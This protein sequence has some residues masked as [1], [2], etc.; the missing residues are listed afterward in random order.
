MKKFISRTIYFV[1]IILSFTLLASCSNKIK[2]TSETSSY[3]LSQTDSYI[4]ESLSESSID[5]ISGSDVE[6]GTI[7]NSPGVSKPTSTSTTKPTPTLVP[8][9]VKVVP[10]DFEPFYTSNGNSFYKALKA[11]VDEAMIMSDKEQANNKPY[12]VVINVTKRNYEMSIPIAISRA[13]NIEINGNGS[14]VINKTKNACINIDKCTNV[15]FSNFTFDYDPLPYTQGVITNIEHPTGGPSIITLKVDAG[16]NSDA[17]S[18][19]GN[20]STFNIHDRATSAPAVGSR[21]FYSMSKVE[22]PSAGILKLTLGWGINDCGAGQKPVVVG[23]VGIVRVFN[24]ACA[25]NVTGSYGTSF[26]DFNLYTAPA[27]GL[28]ENGGDGGMKLTRFN[29]VPGPKPTGATEERLSSVNRDATH[30]ICVKNGPTFESCKIM[31][32]GDDVINVQGFYYFVIKKISDTQYYL[33]PKWDVGMENGDQVEVA[34]KTTFTTKAS[35]KIIAFKKIS[36]TSPALKAAVEAQWGGSSRSPS[37]VPNIAYDVTFDKAISLEIGDAAISLDRNGQNTTV[38]NCTFHGGG[39]V[40]V[41]GSN[42]IVTNNKFSYTLL[43]AIH[44]GSDVGYWAES[45][46]AN[47]TLIKNNT[48]DHCGVS[49]N[50]LFDNEVNGTIYVSMTAPLNRTEK[51]FFNNYMNRKVTIENNTINNSFYYGIVLTNADGAVVKNNKIDQVFLN[52]PFNIG[53]NYG[54]SPEGG[55]LVAQTRNSTITGNTI[56]SKMYLWEALDVKGLC[57]NNTIS[58]NIV[59]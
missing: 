8:I 7:S 57:S 3:D 24:G 59:K 4:Q 52:S 14:T 39:R 27:F 53:Y 50:P 48:F 23:D 37:A 11:A 33:T 54:L 34:D 58:N 43:T 9:N 25:I 31:N 21:Q 49:G 1:A 30:F 41:K 46:F 51:T 28:L 38:N 35:A 45:N 40:N 19:S 15:G 13:S 12:K 22:S 36:A 16:Y 5:G 29:I 56:S 32:S 10:L 20:E 17:A 55:I 2:N 6:S 47:G 44:V 18:L 26:T 42:T